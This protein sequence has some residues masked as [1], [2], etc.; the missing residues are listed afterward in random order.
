MFRHRSF[1]LSLTLLGALA[2]SPA[3]AVTLVQWHGDIA[4]DVT[5]SIRF[6]TGG[7]VFDSIVLSSGSISP[8]DAIPEPN[9]ALRSWSAAS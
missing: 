1:I 9:S 3:S 2:G 5:G 4:I 6:A 7:N 8:A